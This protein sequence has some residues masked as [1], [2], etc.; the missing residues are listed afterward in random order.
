VKQPSQAPYPELR[1]KEDEKC[2]YGIFDEKGYLQQPELPT[3][4][5]GFS[6]AR[7]SCGCSLKTGVARTSDVN[8]MIVVTLINKQIISFLYPV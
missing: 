4:L 1:Q 7:C 8:W 5:N 3:A 6:S 2:V